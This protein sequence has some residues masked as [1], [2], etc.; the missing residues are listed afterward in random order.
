[1]YGLRDDNS[2]AITPIKTGTDDGN[3]I[4]VTDGLEADG[5]VVDAHLKRFVDGQ[6]VS[7]LT[8]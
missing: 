6:K 2:V 5:R 4:E 1:V 7:V 3:Y 8:E